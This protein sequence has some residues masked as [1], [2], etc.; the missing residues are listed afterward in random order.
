M[1][2]FILQSF[3]EAYQAPDVLNA[4]KIGSSCATAEQLSSTLPASS[5]KNLFWQLTK[6]NLKLGAKISKGLKI[7]EATGY[8][9]GST[10]D[11]VYTN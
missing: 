10:L 1:R 7:G 5:I 6:R 2:R 11:F 3:A 4:D 9:A 8:D